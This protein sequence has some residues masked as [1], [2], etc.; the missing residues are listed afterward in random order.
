MKRT[1]TYTLLSCCLVLSSAING[2]AGGPLQ[3]VD[4]SRLEPSPIP[5]FLTAP[6]VGIKWDARSIPVA[7]S[8]NSTLDPIPN[9][10]GAP[11]LS[12][13]AALVA[14]QNAFNS[15]N[16]ITT[17]YIGMEITG[18]TDSPVVAGF[19]FVNEVSFITPPGFGAIAVSPSTSLI[20]DTTLVEG[21]DLDLDGDSDV[22]AAI[23]TAT[24]VDGDGDIEFP[25][26]FYKAGTILDND[27]LFNVDA[28]LGYRFT[29]TE[30]E[31]DADPFAVDLEAV[32]VHEFGHSQ[33]LSHTADNQISN[34]DGNG[35]TMYPFI[36]TGDPRTERAQR[37]L[38]A[39]DIAWSSFF[40]PEGSATTG[41]AAIQQN[42]LPFNLKYGL[43]RGSV[44]HGVLNQPVLGANVFAINEL[45]QQRVV[46]TFSGQ[47]RILYDPFTGG[48]FLTGDPATDLVDGN[49]V[50]PVPL[51]NYSVGVEATDGSPVPAGTISLTAQIGAFYGQQNFNEEFY[52]GRNE[53]A[54]ELD[55]G[56]R[57]RFMILPGQTVSNINFVTSD[58]MNLNNFGVLNFVGFTNPVT[59]GML[60][61]MQV[62]ASQLTAL[63]AGGGLLIQGVAFDTY[64]AQGSVVPTFAKAVLTTGVVNPDNTATV[65]LAQPLEQQ[66]L[67]SGQD[68]DLSPFYFKDSQQLGQR[69]MRGIA[70]GSIQNLFIVL[71]LPT[72]TPFPGLSGQ[73]PLIGLSQGGPNPRMA[74]TS[75]NGGATWTRQTAV[76]F[77]FSLI[78]SQPIAMP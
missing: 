5:G 75:V 48:L 73:P 69:V 20:S 36:D 1:I 13:N 78:L 68:G 34:V 8:L 74:F 37:T 24:D 47:A 64:A 60:Y 59:P 11:V 29:A 9:P 72:T 10:F 7:Y 40:Y 18:F 30:A 6:V 3:T 2:L 54:R 50:L 12:L 42:D 35:S 41:P 58:S 33:G 56:E 45:T 71:Q 27:V 19:D 46:S 53:A 61:A 25:A 26:G 15:W 14:F 22:S 62:P 70:D 77:R 28:N 4:I 23:T 63:G 66:L 55:L 43:I 52:N 51:G 49:Y 31:V 76:N 67:F 65:N 21:D 44:R 39:D 38:A 32:A 16:N 57:T 17:S